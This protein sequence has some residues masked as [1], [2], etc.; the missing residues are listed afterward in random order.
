MN[1]FPMRVALFIDSDVFAGTERHIIELARTLKKPEVHVVIACPSV[2]PLNR[3]AAE[4]N[5]ERIRIEKRGLLDVSAMLRLRRT[6][7]RGQIDVIHAHNGRTALAAVAARRFAGRGAIVATQHF[8]DPAHAGRVGIAAQVSRAAHRWVQLQ[9][10]QYIA[11]SRAAEQA[12][13]AREPALAGK[14]AVIPNGIAAPNRASLTPG[15]G[16]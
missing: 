15:G 16:N 4:L 11:V 3:H 12:M 10:D 14:V 6:L 2:S 9:T 13:V 5:V 8:I 1:E 7:V